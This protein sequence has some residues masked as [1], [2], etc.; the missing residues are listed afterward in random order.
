MK[1]RR[2][3]TTARQPCGC[4]IANGADWSPCDEHRAEWAEHMQRHRQALTD[5]ST[6]MEGLHNDYRRNP[7]QA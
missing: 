6:H 4:I 5:H 2:S 1:P 3:K 7:R